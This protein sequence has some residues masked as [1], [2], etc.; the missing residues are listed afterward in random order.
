MTEL[1]D[2]HEIIA[3]LREVL[4]ARFGKEADDTLIKILGNCIMFDNF[5]ANHLQELADTYR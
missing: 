5:Y 4:N 1:K 2:I 3:D